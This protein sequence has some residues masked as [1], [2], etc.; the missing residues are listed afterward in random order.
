LRILGVIPALSLPIFIGVT[1]WM[2]FA[3][4]TA[5]RQA[6]D[7]TSLLRAVAVC[8]LGWLIYGVLFFGFVVVAL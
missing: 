8:F 3:F 7:Y 4:V 2:L 6:L 5:I 1:L